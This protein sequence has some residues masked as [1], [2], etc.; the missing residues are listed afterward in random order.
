MAKNKDLKSKLIEQKNLL[1]MSMKHLQKADRN[2]KK[3]SKEDPIAND[4]FVRQNIPINY[5]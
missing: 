3:D 2:I 1:E 5:D 4:S